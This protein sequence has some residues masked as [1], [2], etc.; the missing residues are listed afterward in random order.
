MDTVLKKIIC[1]VAAVCC[2]VVF[3][4]DD[5]FAA[6]KKSKPA[7][8]KPAASAM[9]KN[10]SN[11]Q[12]LEKLKMFSTAHVM[13]LNSLIRPNRTSPKITKLGKKKFVATF[14][15]VDMSSVRVELKRYDP[16]AGV[17]LGHITYRQNSFVGE[18]ATSKAATSG[19]YKKR[20]TS[21]KRELVTYRGGAWR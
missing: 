4:C 11:D 14:E 18:G 19:Q 2:A 16:A 17:G 9:I 6:K 8:A 21:N 7:K 20:E 12:V 15:E 5:S 13:K 10:E 3:I 1:F